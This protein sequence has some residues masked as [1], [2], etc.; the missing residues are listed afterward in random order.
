MFYC[1]SAVRENPNK[2]DDVPSSWTR[3]LNKCVNSSNR[4]MG[5]MQLQSKSL[6]IIFQNVTIHKEEQGTKTSPALRKYEKMGRRDCL[7]FHRAR[8]LKATVHAGTGTDKLISRTQEKAQQQG[9][10][11]TDT[12]FMTIVSEGFTVQGESPDQRTFT[13]AFRAR[14]PYS[15]SGGRAVEGTQGVRGKGIFIFTHF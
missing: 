9:H 8:I 2:W 3:Q 15:W 14:G 11:S 5:S 4:Y 1:Y 10:T 13:H 6:W 7:P 12:W